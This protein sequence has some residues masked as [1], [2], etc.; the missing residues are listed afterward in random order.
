MKRHTLLIPLLFGATIFGAS[1]LVAD[2]VKTFSELDT[3]G[4]G[5]ISKQEAKA[6]KDFHWKFRKADKNH[7]GKIDSDEF[8]QFMAKGRFEPPEETES[9]G[10]G[11]AP[12]N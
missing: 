10:I 2:E 4:N 7:D 9:E 1:T 6:S 5:Y 11:A 3:D 8:T 12:M